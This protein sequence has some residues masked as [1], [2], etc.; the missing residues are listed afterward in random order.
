MADA[1]QIMNRLLGLEIT[2]QIHQMALDVGQALR[3]AV[4]WA[5]D[6]TRYAHLMKAPNTPVGEAIA[7]PRRP[8]AP[9]TRQPPAGVQLGEG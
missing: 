1:Q 2:L 8:L 9:T 3:N 7:R 6:G 4:N 5:F